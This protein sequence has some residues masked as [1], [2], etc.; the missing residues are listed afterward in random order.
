MNRADFIAKAGV[1]FWQTGRPAP[2]GSAAPNAQI[3]RRLGPRQ[4]YEEAPGLWSS[5]FALN[6]IQNAA[7]DPSAFKKIGAPTARKRR[8]SAE[9][10]AIEAPPKKVWSRHS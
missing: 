9:Y 2:L 1:I 3:Q 4:L 8:A 6:L 10:F 7:S 5:K